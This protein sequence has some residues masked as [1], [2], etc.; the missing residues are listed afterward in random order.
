MIPIARRQRHIRPACGVLFLVVAFT[1]AARAG[2]D[3]RLDYDRNAG[4]EA[5]PDESALRRS[6]AA[7]L[8]YDPFSPRSKRAVVVR[9]R[10]EGAGHRGT[11]AVE[12]EGAPARA[13]RSLYAAGDCAELVEALALTISVAIDPLAAMRPELPSVATDL[14]A[15]PASV[16]VAPAGSAMPVVLSVGAGPTFGYGIAP[17]PVFGALVYFALRRGGLE[18]I[19]EGNATL[20]GSAASARGRVSSWSA[21]GLA[22]ACAYVSVV[23][24]CAV[25][26]LGVLSADAA[27]AFPRRDTALNVMAGP[28]VGVALTLGKPWLEL[29]L[30]VEGLLALTR[31]RLAI[32]A[33]DVYEFGPGKLGLGAALGARF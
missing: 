17:A 27:V 7:R 29:R 11:V 15:P 33:Q 32:G 26:S 24:G 28:R 14:T 25:A 5:C 12:E 1:R 9:L 6:V 31:H 4:A 22:G 3:A 21:G 18:G 2:Q 8:G 16:T 13:E 20:E 23:F 30:H 19:L 10:H